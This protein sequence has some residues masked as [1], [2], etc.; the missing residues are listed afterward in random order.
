M[1][2]FSRCTFPEVFHCR[3]FR[4][5]SFFS[6]YVSLKIILFKGSSFTMS[7]STATIAKKKA[8]TLPT[9]LDDAS[10]SDVVL[11]Q[12]VALAKATS[13]GDTQK[14]HAKATRKGG[15]QRWLAKVTRKG[16]SQRLAIKVTRK[17]DSQ[18][19]LVK[20]TRK[21]GSQRWLA[22]ATR[23]GDSQRRLAKTCNKGDSQR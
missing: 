21:G 5:D 22:K 18:R 12:V 23:K 4:L 11:E 9:T 15:S 8:T 10:I 2:S 1:L 17:G 19:H 16:D 6:Y 14:Q 7:A 20:A 3:K 13:K